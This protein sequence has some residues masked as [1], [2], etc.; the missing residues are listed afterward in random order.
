MGLKKKLSKCVY[1]GN[2]SVNKEASQAKK[3]LIRLKIE[4]Q[5]QAKIEQKKQNKYKN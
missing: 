5:K 2:D 1:F 4:S 3:A